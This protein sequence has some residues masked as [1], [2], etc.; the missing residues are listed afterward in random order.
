MS[1]EVLQEAKSSAFDE[2]VKLIE[3]ENNDEAI[4]VLENR[5]KENRDDL[6][7]LHLLGTAYALKNDYI[8][9]E[10][11]FKKELAIDTDRIEA[12]FNLGLIHGQQ[13]RL[14]EARDDFENVIRL[15]PDDTQALNDLGV[16]N[17]T[18]GDEAESQEYFARALKIKPAFKEAF[19]NIF[20]LFWNKG[21]YNRALECA[22]NYLKGLVPGIQSGQTPVEDGDR[23][24]KAD[25]AEADMIKPV[26]G[27]EIRSIS[28][29]VSKVITKSEKIKL[30]NRHVPA[31]L[32]D[33]KTG[34]NI[35]MISD[36]DN[37]DQ[38]ALL[39]KLINEN[40]IHRARLIVCDH[41]RVSGNSDII[42]KG[43]GE[44]DLEE[45]AGI[46]EHADFY[47]IGNFP[48]NIPELQVTD[49]IRSNN[50]IV[51][52]YKNDFKDSIDE[53]RAWHQQK[54]IM[55][56]LIDNWSLMRELSA[57]H[58]INLI[59]DL[60][61]INKVSQPENT[62]KIAWQFSE[63][64][65]AS[66]KLFGGAID[67]LKKKYKIEA[68]LIDNENA[69]ERLKLKSQAHM[70]LIPPEE[71]AYGLT[72]IESMAM[73]QVV[74]GRLSNLGAVFY[75]DNPIV[76]VSEKNLAE[77][78][79]YYL[80]DKGELVKKGAMNRAWVENQHNPQ[81]ILRQYLYFYDFIKNGFRILVEPE[82]Q[83]LRQ[84][85]D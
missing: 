58:H 31:V 83:L 28:L 15:K 85:Y 57:W 10:K 2:A 65:S 73:G 43:G 69:E 66:H 45:A 48:P 16:I 82:N 47:H 49:Y 38:L 29:G 36:K 9:A 52:Y 79:E 76:G 20:E 42:L 11:I 75:P 53:I 22:L 84:V 67:R 55:S 26:A 25:A 19:L 71:D 74:F 51:Q 7:A 39:F 30:F 81:K 68:L 78:I 61:H 4:S 56:V 18:L 62:I 63:K 59:Y 12:Y 64:D 32:R 60:N 3:N 14:S 50:T 41:N 24:N 6:K 21:Q 23:G 37:A 27:Q 77:K 1:S 34:I 13:N 5:L 72:A 33:K 70:T 46:I 40:T 17:Y 8:N 80:K 44:S 35:A 54:N